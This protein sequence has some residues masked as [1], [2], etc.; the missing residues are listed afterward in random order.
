MGISTTISNQNNPLWYKNA[1]FY[2]VYPRSFMDSNGDG[3][4]DFQGLISRLDYI[5]DLGVDCIWLQPIYPSPLNDDGYDISDYT[6]VHESFGTIDDMKQLVQEVHKRGMRLIADLVLNHCSSDHPWFQAARNDPTS[7]YFDYFVWSDDPKKYAEARVIFLDSLDSN[8]TFDEKVGKYYWHRFYPSQPDLNFDNPEVRDAMKDVLRF[9]LDLGIDGFRAD[10]VPYLY[11]REGTNGENLP[12]THAY[13]KE[14]RELMDREYPG[15]ILLCE[16][17]QWPQDVREYFGDGDEFQLGFHF[18]LMP[19]IFMSIGKQDA[20]SLIDILKATPEIPDTCQWCVFLRNH[21]ELTLEMVTEEDRQWMWGHYAPDRAMRMNLGIRRRLY[22]LLENDPRKIE[23]AYSMIFTLPGSPVLYYGDEIGMGDDI[24]QFDRNGVRTPM[25]WNTS[26]NGGFS[27]SNSTYLPAI[28]DGVNG[29]LATNVAAQ[30]DD[31]DSNL[32]RLKRMI[33]IRK[34]SKALGEGK[35]IW[36]V[37]G[38]KIPVLAH[39]RI[40]NNDSVIA[41]HNVSDN[42]RTLT[43]TADDGTYRD[44]LDDTVCVDAVG[45]KMT[46]TLAPRTFRWLRKV[47]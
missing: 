2:Q 5:R 17:N 21:D 45:G 3:Y 8:W 16:A 9:W 26:K 31:P 18:P 42:E 19:R 30:L 11:E 14:L 35:L 6:S 25:Q 15:T 37:D 46:V 38:T 39:A 10:A 4:G 28:R 1:V 33:A 20:S 36:L 32:N 22:P 47:A 34:E 24:T 23:L 27:T 13:L 29:Y 41:L 7:K 44:L 12:E 40:A 43:L